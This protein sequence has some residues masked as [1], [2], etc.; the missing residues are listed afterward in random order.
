MLIEEHD[1]NQTNTSYSG[2]GTYEWNL[3]G[4]TDRQLTI[5][6]HRML[7]YATIYKSVKN[8]DRNICKMII[9]GFIGQ[10]RG[11]WDNYMSIEAKVA[12]VNGIVDNE[13]VDNL[14]ISLVRNKEENVYTLVL[15]IL[16]HFNGRLTNQYETVRSLLNGL[17]CRHLGE[18]R[19]YKDTYLSRVRELPKNGL[20]HWKAKFIG[21]LPPLFA[22][23]L[24]DFC[25]QFGLPD[26]ATKGTRP[27]DSS[28]S[29]P[30]K[31]HRKQRSR[32]R[33]R[34]EREE[35]KAH[36]YDS[37]S[38]SEHADDQPESSDN[39]QP[40][41]IDA[42]K[43][44]VYNRLA[45][46][47]IVIRDTS[48]DDLKGE[49]ENLKQEIKMLKQNQTICDHRLTQIESVNNKVELIITAKGFSATYKDR[50]ISYTKS[51]PCQMNAELVE[52]YKT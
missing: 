35:Q 3:V 36:H 43:C 27:R 37:E 6:V 40:A 15:T 47:P 5:L 10:F 11:W 4:L 41:T 28:G 16:E 14:G 17:R 42:C 52:F 19:W 1:W 46:Q 20:E 29:N 33:S 9:A 38:S 44:Q 34:E 49:I 24:G 25:T 13:G 30:E 39:N 7:M 22:E 26:I 21:G 31:P 50:D 12:V 2:T 51:R 32:Q 48:F 45:K 23:R 18:V 8:T